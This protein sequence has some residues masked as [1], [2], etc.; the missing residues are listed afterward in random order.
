MVVV[1]PCFIAIT[2]AY[3][4]TYT[5]SSPFV[6][7]ITVCTG[8]NFCSPRKQTG[9]RDTFTVY[10]AW[11]STVVSGKKHQFEILYIFFPEDVEVESALSAYL[12]LC[13]CFCTFFELIH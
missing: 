11:R 10:V 5:P 3:L 6:Y 2:D 13:N 1:A 8:T 4:G 9:G 7:Q 12:R